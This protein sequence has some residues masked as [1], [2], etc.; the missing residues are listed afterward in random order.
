MNSLLKEAFDYI[1][2]GRM[3]Y[4]MEHRNFPL[5]Y[6]HHLSEIS[7]HHISSIVEVNQLGHTD[8][9][10]LWIHRDPISGSNVSMA[11][12]VSI[13]L[14]FFWTLMVAIIT[15]KYRKEYHSVMPL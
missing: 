3:V 12:E 13:K 14:S 9:G 5:D 4:D 15:L 1:G 8:E 7:L 6:G 2:S 11:T 10:K